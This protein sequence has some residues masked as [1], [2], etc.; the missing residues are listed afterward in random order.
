MTRESGTI[1]KRF[2]QKR[3]DTITRLP[4][5]S[6]ARQNQTQHLRSKIGAMNLLANQKP[7]EAD[8]FLQMP[9]ASTGGPTDPRV[10]GAETKCCWSESQRT[11]PSMSAA[12]KISHLSADQGGIATRMLLYDQVVPKAVQR[13]IRSG[14]KV[15]LQSLDFIH[16]AGYVFDARQWLT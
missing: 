10:T 6:Q 1:D 7:G 3:P 11:Q 5:V 15:Q 2:D 16:P 8:N 4:V 9:E 12:N 14:H 13:I